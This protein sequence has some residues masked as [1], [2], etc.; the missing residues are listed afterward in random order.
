MLLEQ[1]RRRLLPVTGLKQVPIF[2]GLDEQNIGRT[3]AIARL[4]EVPANEILLKEGEKAVSAFVIKSG[5]LA[6]HLETSSGDSRLARCCFP[7][8][9]VG[10]S[11]MLEGSAATCNAT[12]KA[13]SEAV[14]WQF[15]GSDLRARANELPELRTR[16]EAKRAF[17]RLDSF[18]STNEVTDSLDVRVRDKLLGCISSIR[19]VRAGEVLEPKGRQPESAYLIIDGRIE[20]VKPGTPPRLYE[21]DSFAAVSDTL[22]ELP[23]EGDFIAVEPCR[24]VSF[25]S[26]ALRELARK[27]PPEVISVLERLE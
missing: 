25:N 8:E 18:F 11:S 24:L 14:L 27:A 9:L 1:L 6:I 3:N 13:K 23:L 26:D 21:P 19:H 12:V 17:N 10:E 5:V 16:I 2:S 20:Y 22:H 4:I 15:E 7:G